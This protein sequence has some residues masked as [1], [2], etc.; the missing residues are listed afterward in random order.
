[1]F[2]LFTNATPSIY[3][4]IYDAITDV[5]INEGCINVCEAEMEEI[6][7]CLN[8]TARYAWEDQQEIWNLTEYIQ[9]AFDIDDLEGCAVSV[10]FPQTFIDARMNYCPQYDYV[11]YSDIEVCDFID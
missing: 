11:D 10:V 6:F 9:D 4:A 2:K 8:S 3:V 7:S 1:M 5:I